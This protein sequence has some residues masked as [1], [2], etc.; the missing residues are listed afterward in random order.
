MSPLALDQIIEC[1]RELSDKRIQETL[2]AGKVAGQQSDFVEAVEVL[3]TDTDLGAALD[4]HATGFS[5][6]IESK[7]VELNVQ[8]KKVRTNG[9]NPRVVD[10]PAMPRVRELANQA[11]S[12]IETEQK[13]RE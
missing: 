11:L 4:R 9:H 3:F 1:L 13:R 10:D 5:H 6:E 12:M 2:W 8:L 7:L